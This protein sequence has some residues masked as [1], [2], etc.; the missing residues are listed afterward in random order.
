MPFDLDN[1][2]V[3]GISSSALFDAREEDRLFRE[4]GQRAFIDYQIANEDRPFKKGTA[5]P[6][7][8]GL[9]RLNTLSKKQL[10][11]VVVLSHNNPEAGLRAMNSLE[12]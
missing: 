2:L 6:L 4:Q 1:V 10:V 7:I 5:F 12:L 9:L 3:V 11:E 8:E